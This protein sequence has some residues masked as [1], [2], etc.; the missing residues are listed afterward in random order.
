MEAII[1]TSP[2]PATIAKRL[3]S[4]GH[5][6]AVDPVACLNLRK[7]IEESSKKK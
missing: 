6:D 1:M 4:L 2:A 7:G 5:R 3:V